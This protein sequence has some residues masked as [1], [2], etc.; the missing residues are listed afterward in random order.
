[1]QVECCERLMSL[2]FLSSI[3][4]DGGLT[5]KDGMVKMARILLLVIQMMTVVPL[6]SQAQ[7]DN[8]STELVVVLVV[9]ARSIVARSWHF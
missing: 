8:I 2:V 5:E 7:S 4:T 6:S 9:V 3:V 1:M